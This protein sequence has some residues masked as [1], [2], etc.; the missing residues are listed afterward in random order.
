MLDAIRNLEDLEKLANQ[1][2]ILLDKSE[3]ALAVTRGEQT[4]RQE[5]KRII[6]RLKGAGLA[7]QGNGKW[8]CF[9][10]GKQLVPL[11]QVLLH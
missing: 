6:K 9:L 5:W 1:R 11:G 10:R 7:Y 8:H 3:V 4:D 2:L